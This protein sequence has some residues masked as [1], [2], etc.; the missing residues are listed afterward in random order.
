MISIEEIKKLRDMTGISISE[1]R[2]ALEKA[3]GDFERAKEVLKEMGKGF[4]KKRGE[5]E[6]N[7][8][9]IEAYIHS[10]KKIGVMVELLCESDFVARSEDF[11]KLAHEL[12]LQIAAINPD[13][14]PLMEQNWIKDESKS[15]KELFDEY[16]AKFGEN[17]VLKKFARFEI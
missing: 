10:G 15:V 2:K 7:S 4:V 16:I 5:R 8:G 1:C 11:Q 3:G 14:F 6:T 17:I 13:E 12:C 9:I